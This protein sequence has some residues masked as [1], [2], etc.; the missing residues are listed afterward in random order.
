M[1]RILLLSEI[2]QGGEWIATKRL[3]EAVIEYGYAEVDLVAFVGSNVP[4]LSNTWR[5]AKFI[6][7]SQ[8]TGRCG[9]LRNLVE[10][11]FNIRK[12]ISKIATPYDVIV[13]T[14]YLSM[15][16]IMNLTSQSK[17]PKISFFHGIKSK[18]F[19][20]WK[21]IN[22][23]ILLPKFLEM[24]SWSWSNIIIVPS[25]FAKKYI[26]DRIWQNK[27]LIPQ[28]VVLP[29][30][31]SDAFFTNISNIELERYRKKWKLP[32]GKL[33][34]YVGRIDPQKGLQRLVSVSEQLGFTLII[35]YPSANTDANLVYWLQ[36]KPPNTRLILLADLS[37]KELSILY[38]LASVLVLLSELEFAPLVLV[39]A[40]AGGCV[41][42]ASE[43][44]NS[45]DLLYSIDPNLLVYNQDSLNVIQTKVRY[46]LNLKNRNDVVWKGLQTAKKHDKRNVL[47]QFNHL[48]G[49]L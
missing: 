26:T 35:A 19:K 15:L 28:F 18:P 31:V 1:K 32:A 24:V 5:N 9:F 3:F 2:V 34:L 43:C 8:H 13:S 22:Y 47:K 39:E 21:D 41:C 27:F 25:T 45:K 16:A 29:N 20:N 38:R 37:E 12:V 33:L 46:A 36:Q 4:T 6:K 14:N 44:G 49:K 40:M 11:F 10:D 23:R 30:I 17:V 7:Y 48:L 42:V